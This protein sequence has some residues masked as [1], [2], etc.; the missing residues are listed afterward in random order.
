MFKDIAYI[1]TSR[2]VQDRPVPAEATHNIPPS[3]QCPGPAELISHP[4][5]TAPA[6]HRNPVL[7]PAC[8]LQLLG[9]VE[10]VAFQGAGLE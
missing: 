7:P 2:R 9:Q 4:E 3:W 1:D 5:E 10:I 8:D 6:P